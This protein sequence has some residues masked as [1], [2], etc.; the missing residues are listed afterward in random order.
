MYII[1]WEMQSNIH[2][3]RF[4]SLLFS[5][6]L[7][8]SVQFLFDWNK[9]IKKETFFVIWTRKPIQWISPLFPFLWFANVLEVELLIYFIWRYGQITQTAF[10]KIFTKTAP[11]SKIP[12]FFTNFPFGFVLFH[13][14]FVKTI[15]HLTFF[16]STFF[17]SGYYRIR[18]RRGFINYG[19]RWLQ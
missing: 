10:F 11:K 13:S 9:R 14:L 6:L 8:Q 16:S 1:G 15:S 5:N 2:A 19:L 3:K 17:P 18:F 4:F 12:K 7:P